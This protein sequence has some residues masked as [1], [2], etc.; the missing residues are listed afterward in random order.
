MNSWLS[1][2]DIIKTACE[3]LSQEYS[4]RIQERVFYIHHNYSNTCNDI[5]D[6][7]I[8][9]V[10]HLRDNFDERIAYYRE[11]IKFES[12]EEEVEHYRKSI[13]AKPIIDYVPPTK[14]DE[15][16][17]YL[18]EN[19]K[20]DRVSLIGEYV[21]GVRG[22]LNRNEVERILQQII[23]AKNKISNEKKSI[24]KSLTLDEKINDEIK[25]LSDLLEG[26]LDECIRILKDVLSENDRHSLDI[27]SRWKKRKNDL[28]ILVAWMDAIR[29]AGK[30]KMNSIDDRK[31]SELLNAQF[32]GIDFKLNDTSI[33]RKPTD[34]YNQYKQL[35]DKKLKY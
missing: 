9:I 11:P 26:N 19:H 6:R 4:D 24:N 15:E 21:T 33:W 30:F 2:T 17:S 5:L 10:T 18:R 8:K 27:N 7:I 13:R 28:S 32:P 20:V 35:F 14:T 12:L 16:I 29:Q 31:K 22:E 25:S 3:F 34:T 23:E 1:R